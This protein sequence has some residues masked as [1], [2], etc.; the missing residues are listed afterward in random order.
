MGRR[1][2]KAV[3]SGEQFARHRIS[4]LV[5]SQR[6]L[7]IALDITEKSIWNYE[8]DTTPITRA[9]A[10]RLMAVQAPARFAPEP[11]AIP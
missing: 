5:M 1:P 9:V 11:E 4:R 8:H 6:E 3:M 10:D 7:A 2:G